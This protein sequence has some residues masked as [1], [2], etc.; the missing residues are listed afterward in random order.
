MDKRS[1]TTFS[2]CVTF[3]L[4]TTASANRPASG[5]G[6]LPATS[7]AR[8]D[9]LPHDLASMRFAPIADVAPGN[10]GRLQLVFAFSTGTLNGLVAAPLVVGPTMYLVTPFPNEVYALDLTQD[11]APVRWKFAPKPAA[12]AQGVACCDTVNRGLAYDDGKL[13]FNTLD[14]QTIALDAEKGKELWRYRAGDVNGGETRTMAPLVV[15]DTV[16]IGNSG[17][18]FGVRGWLT[19]LD[20]RTGK[21]KWRAYS[22]GPD[23]DVRIGPQYHPYYAKDA[24]N[25]LGLSTWPADLWKVG[26]GTP[27]DGSPTTLT[28]VSSTTGRRDQRQRTANNGSGTTNSLPE[29]L[30]AMLAPAWPAGFTNLRR[31]TPSAMTASEATS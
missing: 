10:V 2:A 5:A 16:F 25:D 26:G 13:F 23:A 9:S 31:T 18:T 19:A 12:Y 8:S 30:H 22:T 17:T 28:L 24:G 3:A 6:P 4:L 1:L 15:R 20:E 11:G 14:N 27:G 29:Y 7:D 21:E